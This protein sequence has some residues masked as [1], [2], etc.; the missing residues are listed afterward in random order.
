M[1]MCRYAQSDRDGQFT[2]IFR[3]YILRICNG[4]HLRRYIL[5]TSKNPRWGWGQGGIFFPATENGAGMGGE[6]VIGDGDYALRS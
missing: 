3:R 6:D 2:P 4:F 5:A 1:V